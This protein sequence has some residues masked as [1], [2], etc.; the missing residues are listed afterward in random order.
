MR[1]VR[2]V[3]DPLARGKRNVIAIK[4]HDDSDDEDNDDE[5]NDDEGS[6]DD[7]AHQTTST[8][9][10]NFQPPTQYSS[11]LDQQG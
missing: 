4:L 11:H 7:G 1:G 2:G 3:E 10:G 9:V 5:D 6:N 8:C